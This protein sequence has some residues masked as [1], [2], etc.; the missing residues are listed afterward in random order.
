[1]SLETS[2]NSL[3]RSD[4]PGATRVST[5]A[6]RWLRQQPAYLDLR[7]STREGLIRAWRR[8][9]IQRRILRTHPI[10][11]LRSGRVEVRA[12]SWRR[13][14]IDLIW[15]LK[16]FYFFS[17][18][19]YPLFIHD[20]GFAPG[21]SEILQRH[22]PNATIVSR[23]ESDKEVQ[24]ILSRRGLKR[25]LEY[26]SRNVTTRKLFDFFLLSDAQH[27]I[28]IDSDIIFFRNPSMLTQPSEDL[29]ENRYNKDR[30]CWY[31]MTT[32]E[33][34]ASFGIRPLECINSGLSLV[35]RTSIDF[36]AIE[37]WLEHP[38]L[39]EDRWVTEQTLHALASAKYGVR[40]LPDCYMV[41]TQRGLAEDTVC[42]HYTG[43]FRPYHYEEGMAHLIETE[44]LDALSSRNLH[45]S[46]VVNRSVS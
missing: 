45:K 21:Q 41:S 44:F 8:R 22:F 24:S 14:C 43:F 26:R 13:D 36:S 35:R 2:R 30:S 29:H 9:R 19:E 40:L 18:V 5:P 10:Y 46:S 34:A 37:Q 16:S 38:K 31:S 15:A 1:L 39:F 25:C 28:S 12:L 6:L 20:G 27:I 17:Q 33:M 23:E 32:E 3:I 4:R 42:K 11:T 7:W